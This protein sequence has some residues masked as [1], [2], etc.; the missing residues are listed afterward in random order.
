[1]KLQLVV[2][3]E[4]STCFKFVHCVRSLSLYMC[5]LRVA[6]TFKCVIALSRRWL[7]L[8]DAFSVNVRWWLRILCN[9]YMLCF[10]KALCAIYRW[11]HG[12][13]FPQG[14]LLLTWINFYP[15]MDTCTTST[16]K[17][18]MKLLINSQTIMVAHLEVC[19][20]IHDFM[21]YVITDVI[22]YPCWD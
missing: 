18:V 6:N 21:P 7:H 10:R 5:Q 1:M 3:W 14:P 15:S 22:T 9:I 19:E 13:P 16:V 4:I 11:Y 20:W 8:I 12:L 17:C 2:Q